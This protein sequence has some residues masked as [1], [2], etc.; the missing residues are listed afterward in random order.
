MDISRL[1][2][3]YDRRGPRYTSYPTAVDFH[4]SFTVAD[5]EAALQRADAMSE[6]PWSIYFHIPFCHARCTF[7]ACSVIVSPDPSRVSLPYV[8]HLEREL[9]LVAERIANRRRVAQLHWGGGTPTYLEPALIERLWHQIRR[10]FELLPDAEVAIEVDPRVT[11]LEHLEMLAKCGFNRIS[12]GVQDFD[13]AVQQHIGRVQSVAATRELCDRASGS[14][15]TCCTAFPGRRAAACPERW[16][17]SRSC[18]RTALRSMAM[19]TCRAF[20]ETSEPSILRCCPV[21]SS[22]SSSG[23]SRE[24]GC[25]VRG[26]S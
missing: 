21:P 2:Q 15:S 22:V 16:I 18:G 12:A 20:G 13:D 6:E 17:W 10:H 1:V 24:P 4:E 7:C 5:Y 25:R 26:T 3:K 11:G 8:E 14:T 19:P 9:E 23:H